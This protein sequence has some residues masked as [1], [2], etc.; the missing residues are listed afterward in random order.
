MLALRHPEQTNLAAA[1]LAARLPARRAGDPLGLGL[2]G[3]E[4]A[5]LRA[6]PPDPDAYDRAREDAEG[7]R[8]LL[9]AAERAALDAEAF[10][11][12]AEV[13]ALIAENCGRDQLES[14]GLDAD[15][16]LIID[17]RINY[18]IFIAGDNV[19]TREELYA[20]F[21]FGEF[22][23]QP[24]AVFAAQEVGVFES[25]G[26][27]GGATGTCEYAL[28]DAGDERLEFRLA[29]DLVRAARAG[30]GGAAVGAAPARAPT[31]VVRTKIFVGREA[32]E[33][34]CLQTKLCRG[35]VRMAATQARPVG[36]LGAPPEAHSLQAESYAQLAERVARLEQQVAELARQVAGPVATLSAKE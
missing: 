26:T 36:L 15:L 21:P 5:A 31:R 35:A 12:P 6:A 19:Y 30:A 17:A 23:T 10:L 27:S 32:W 29:T 9:T 4:A 3:A 33:D 25:V 18:K 2:G 22:G 11:T 34:F 16:L 8:S 7:A 13:R 28:R 14:V 1:A 20:S 24:E